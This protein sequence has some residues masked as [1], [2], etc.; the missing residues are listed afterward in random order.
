MVIYTRTGDK[1]KTIL[2]SGNRATKSE[3]IFDVLG[4]LDELT[5]I[6]GY[7]HTYS[8]TKIKTAIVSLQRDLFCL[9]AL[10]AGAKVSHADAHYFEKLTTQLEKSIDDLSAELP[11]LKN[12]ILPGADFYTTTMHVARAVCRRLERHLVA[13]AWPTQKPEHLIVLAYL[14]RLSDYFFV[15]AR[16]ICL[17]GQHTELLWE[18]KNPV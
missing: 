9:G 7:F 2:Y 10:L 14:N 3:R 18:G 1:G 16:T 17:A 5:A 15:L 4:T 13:Y 8:D 6:L 11:P 12:F